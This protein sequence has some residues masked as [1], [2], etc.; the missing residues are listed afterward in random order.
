MVLD[1]DRN[2]QISVFF[3]YKLPKLKMAEPSYV[4]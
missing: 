3:T 1:V 4:F 2:K